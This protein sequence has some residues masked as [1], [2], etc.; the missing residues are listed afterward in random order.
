MILDALLYPA[1]GQPRF[2]FLRYTV[3]SRWIPFSYLMETG[4]FPMYI[5]PSAPELQFVFSSTG[6]QF[7]VTSVAI[8]PCY[9]FNDLAV[10]WQT[11]VSFV[12]SGYRPMHGACDDGAYFA[13]IFIPDKEFPT[14]GSHH[15]RPASLRRESILQRITADSATEVSGNNIRS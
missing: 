3:L 6:R 9:W 4:P 8:Y 12:I 15:I 10:G 13:D 2:F 7:L 14:A 1:T 5:Y 11:K